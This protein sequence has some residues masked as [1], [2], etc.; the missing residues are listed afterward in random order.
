MSKFTSKLLAVVFSL[1]FIA[2]AQAGKV[3][4]MTVEGAKSVSAAEA[5]ALFDKGVIFLDV[6]SDK[7]W[8]AGRIPDAIHIEL[9]KKLRLRQ[10][11]QKLKIQ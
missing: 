8:A 2:T 10:L 9:K 7:D 4:P 11:A 5:K 6:R 1:A 3:S